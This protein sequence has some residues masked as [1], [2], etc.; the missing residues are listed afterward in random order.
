MA[1]HLFFLTAAL[2][3]TAG[4]AAAQYPFP[5]GA[6]GYG[7][8]TS[9]VLSPYLN[10]MNGPGNAGVNYYNFVRPQLALQQAQAAYGAMGPVGGF[11]QYGLASTLPDTRW[12]DRIPRPT[13]SMT[14]TPATFNAYGSYFNNMG[15]IGA[16]G[17]PGQQV[18][19]AAAP[20]PGVPNIP[21]R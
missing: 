5:Y 19:A 6:P 20:A 21:R 13:G 7:Q 17:R 2:L 10:L 9:P 16:Y 15:T 14:G 3:A 12:Y 1:R 4:P 18:G 8:P 11:D